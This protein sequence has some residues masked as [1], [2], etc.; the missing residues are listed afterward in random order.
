MIGFPLHFEMSIKPFFKQVSGVGQ[1]HFS[2]LSVD[3]S[4]KSAEYLL[5]L[6]PSY[7]DSSTNVATRDLKANQGL[8][9]VCKS[10]SRSVSYLDRNS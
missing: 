4:P 9:F 5:T 6:I 8:K 7:F 3:I 2:S 1:K 10:Q